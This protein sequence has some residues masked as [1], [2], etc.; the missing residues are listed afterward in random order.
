MQHRLRLPKTFTLSD[1]AREAL[2]RSNNASQYIERL[3]EH[4]PPPNPETLGELAEL[5]VS[6]HPWAVVPGDRI[7]RQGLPTYGGEV[8]PPEH[9]AASWDHTRIMTWTGALRSRRVGRKNSR[10]PKPID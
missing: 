8:P 3:L 6:E 9:G 5:V 1:A 10:G 4:Y 7:A 2:G